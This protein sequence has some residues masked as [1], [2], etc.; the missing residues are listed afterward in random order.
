MDTQ[1]TTRRCPLWI[2]IVL[3]LSLALNLAVIGLVSGFLLRG[4]PDGARLPAMG[5]AMPYVMALPKDLRRDVFNT[6]R[7][8]DTLPDRRAR[9]AEYGAMIAVLRATPYDAEA[10]RA[11]LARQAD[12]VSRVQNV[13]QS[14][15]LDAVASLSDAE[16]A[17]YAQN[18]Q[19]AL[20]R[21][22]GQGRKERK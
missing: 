22:G 21:R 6:V 2:K 18:M 7:G 14:A 20:K 9:R 10:A 12:G 5:Y 16:R 11:I 1:D 17:T 13:A 3:A 15:W 8:D 19:E 4:G